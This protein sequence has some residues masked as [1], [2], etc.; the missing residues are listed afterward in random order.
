MCD[1]CRQFFVSG[2]VTGTGGSISIRFGDRIYMTPSGVQK[3]RIE[4]EDVFV[5]D[6]HGNML[7][8]PTRKPGTLR[9]PKLSECSPLFLVA[10]R[11]RKAGAV[12]HSHDMSCNIVSAM[13]EGK[14]EWRIRK[15]EMIKG[16]TGHG[17]L[18]ELVIPI[19]DNTPHEHELTASLEDAV[20]KYPKAVGVLVRHHG[21][22]VWGGSWEEAKRHGEVLHYLFEIS[23]KLCHL[24]MAME[25]PTALSAAAGMGRTLQDASVS[26]APKRART[27][28]SNTVSNASAYKAILLD[29]E[30][31]TTP[32]TFVKDT[33]F[34]F[35]ASH[36]ESYLRRTWGSEVT[37][38]DVE[39]LRAQYLADKK[40]GIADLPHS[41]A[42]DSEV[43]DP[44]R[45]DVLGEAVAYVH[46]SIAKDRKV[47]ALKDLQGRIWHDGFVSGQLIAQVYEDV[48][49]FLKS[50]Q[51]AGIPVCIYSSGSRQAQKLLFGHSE[52][53]NLRP[54]L[55]AYFDTS[56]G[57][58]RSAESYTEIFNTLNVDIPSDIL[59]VT[60]IYEEA[61]A[62]AQ[63][64]LH[65]VIS[66]RPGNAALPEGNTFKTI[67]SF[68]QL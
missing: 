30:G 18:D 17:Y 64:G 28:D 55:S 7:S 62:A 8:V 16:I 36:V 39:A 51:S 54:L 19:I 61:V 21:V 6:L 5:L 15:Q 46:W 9:A 44:R 49:R 48:P 12:L 67:T 32:I 31:T 56:V 45:T 59:F 29:I 57:N 41:K 1:L 3:E 37:S 66:V 47:R 23:L 2:W 10:F 14:S 33:M 38:Q 20:L 58:K 60:D 11:H 25:S 42:F 4:P 65:A 26:S 40:E 22:Y 13:C 27:A 63:A 52:R 68:D 43:F 50:M 34:P 24:S 35:A 53:G